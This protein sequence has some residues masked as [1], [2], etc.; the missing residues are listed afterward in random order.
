MQDQPKQGVKGQLPH[1]LGDQDHEP[2][3]ARDQLQ[4]GVK[5]QIQQDA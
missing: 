5:G 2:R 1:D 3:A 4:Q